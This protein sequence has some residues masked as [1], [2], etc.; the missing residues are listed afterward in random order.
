LDHPVVSVREA[1]AKAKAKA[2]AE[3]RH[4]IAIAYFGSKSPRPISDGLLVTMK[5]IVENVTYEYKALL[6]NAAG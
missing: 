1:K 3:A 5:N 4:R 2:K 6:S